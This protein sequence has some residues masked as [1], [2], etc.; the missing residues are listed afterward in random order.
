MPVGLDALEDLLAVVQHGCGGVEGD[1]AVGLDARTVP[2]AADRPADVD[3]VVG[4]ARAE[5]GID[6]DR[7]TLGGALR[8][9]VSGDGEL[10]GGESGVGLGIDEGHVVS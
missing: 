5:A 10:E 9:E 6:E 7:L 4:E 1:R 8:G 2:A 3:H